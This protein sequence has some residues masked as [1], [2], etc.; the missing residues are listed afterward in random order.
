MKKVVLSNAIIALLLFSLSHKISAQVQVSPQK[1]LEIVEKKDLNEF[2]NYLNSLWPKNVKEKQWP[3]SRLATDDFLADSLWYA[4]TSS[5]TIR[6][7]QEGY[8]RMDQQYASQ[9]KG[10]AKVYKIIEKVNSNDAT[11]IELVRFNNGH[12]QLDMA[13][14]K[15]KADIF[16]QYLKENGYQK[17][18]SKDESRA[19]VWEGQGL[20]IRFTYEGYG[21]SIYPTPPKLAK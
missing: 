5:F 9:I 10:K 14:R 15:G 17:V 7:R 20:T 3:I 21:I 12:F 16:R 2:T 4:D 18:T 1:M 19:E 11:V 13:L 8:G 6:T